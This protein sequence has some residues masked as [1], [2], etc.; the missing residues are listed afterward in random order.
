MSPESQAPRDRRLGWM[1]LEW[2]CVAFRFIRSE[3]FARALIAAVDLTIAVYQT[4]V[5]TTA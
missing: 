5:V 4:A 1:I 3:R 2:L